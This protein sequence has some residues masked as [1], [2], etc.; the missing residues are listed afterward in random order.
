[1][2]TDFVGVFSELKVLLR[3]V[4]SLFVF[5]GFPESCK[6]CLEKGTV[7]ESNSLENNSFGSSF[8]P[9]SVEI[10]F[11][12]YES[13]NAFGLYLGVVSGNVYSLASEH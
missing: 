5:G 9:M 4:P 7:S 2:S 11:S 6:L 13:D 8:G 12:E 3:L 10:E 1:M